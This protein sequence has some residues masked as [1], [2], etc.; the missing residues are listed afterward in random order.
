MMISKRFSTIRRVSLLLAILIGFACGPG[1]E[2]MGEF[3]SLF[4]PGSATYSS[5]DSRYIF[6]PQ[7]YNAG[8]FGVDDA[9][10]SASAKANTDAWVIYL[11]AGYP[12]KLVGN[13]LADTSANNPLISQLKGA[14]P[15]AA[16]YL[17]FAYT[18][19]QASGNGSP[20]GEAQP[21]T[22]QLARLAAQA[23]TATLATNDLFL[24]ERYAFQAVK[25]ADEAGLF[26]QS[27]DNYE[28][29]VA[30]LPRQ[31]FISGWAR[32]RLAGALLSLGQN[33]RS[34]F[35]FA[36]VFANCPTRR[37]AAER[38]LRHH[39]LRFSDEALAFAKTDAERVA[40]LAICAIQPKQDALPLLE[41][42][43][44]LDPKNPLIELV[45]AREINRNEY[46]FAAKQF[47][48][49]VE[50]DETRAD[51]VAFETR[52]KN[53]P[54]YA[55]KLLSFTEKAAKN[56]ALGNPAY[57]LTAA[58]YLQ[59]L[60]GDYTSA[61]TTLDQAA[62]QPT[63]NQTLKQQMALQ[64][65]LLLAAQPGLPDAATETAL[66]SY[67]T[68]FKQ[69]SVPDTTEPYNT[70][71]RFT[72]AIQTVGKQVASRYTATDD[73]Q[74]SSGWLSGCSQKKTGDSAQMAQTGPRQAKAFLMRLITTGNSS[75][76]YSLYDFDAQMALEDSTSLRT[77]RNL[78]DY[79]VNPG[80]EFDERLVKL[81][82]IDTDYAYQLLGR[83]AM[84]EENYQAAAAAFANVK[85]AVW[86]REAVRNNFAIDPFSV[87]MPGEGKP[88]NPYTPA[89]FASK[90][91]DLLK[92]AI[93]QRNADQR[94]QAWYTLGCGA[95]NL[96]YYGN[97]W[98]MQ[99]R[100]RSSAEPYTYRYGATEVAKL[101]HF[102]ND[103]Y[104][105]AKTA[106]VYFSQAAKQAKSQELAAKATYMAARCEAS[107]LLTRRVVEAAKTGGYVADDDSV[108]NAKMRGLA[109]SDY[110]TF[111][112]T[113]QTRY[114]QTQFAQQMQT[115]CAL[116]RDFMAGE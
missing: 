83:R 19:Q 79:V 95:Y 108:F 50:N 14:K 67:L 49:Y 88:R 27:R 55:G 66:I 82:G 111:L 89:Q 110:A 103:P 74:K 56:P 99:H 11:G 38:S 114:R 20:W 70:N 59:Y 34:V 112:K 84:A 48:G 16:T 12:S 21:D 35:E 32:C 104:Y 17:R 41:K 58:A 98:F 61:K 80:S 65:M 52:R 57:Y 22:V 78:A 73:G 10:D 28:Q 85:P 42:M 2:E 15:E 81:A 69:A 36:Q 102:W 97:A 13:A 116:Y 24:K 94:A 90:M 109:A 68:Q 7:L 106:Q 44:D 47:P 37:L 40:V 4:Q 23:R 51:S 115:R 105:T 29:L 39:G 6:T 77:A 3:F 92:Q 5:A 45:L 53:V 101:D 46:Y 60:S 9:P 62:Q 107:A 1:A 8:L 18:A 96:T 26:S 25:L 64:Q 113:Y 75:A 43:V 33:N 71:F 87:N 86:Q 76:G 91:A 54:E 30:T 31:S 93:S 72:N 63:A 100:F